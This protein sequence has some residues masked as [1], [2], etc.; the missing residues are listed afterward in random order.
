MRKLFVCGP[1]CF[2]PSPSHGLWHRTDRCV[3]FIG[4]PRCGAVTGQMCLGR[5]GERAATHA[6]RRRL[7]T[8]TLAKTGEDRNANAVVV[9]I[10]DMP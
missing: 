3:A 4:C 9:T 6:M 7:Y 8:S 10:E 1:Y 2:V 5:D